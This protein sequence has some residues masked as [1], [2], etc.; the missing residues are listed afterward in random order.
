MTG[1]ARAVVAA[2]RRSARREEP[3]APRAQLPVAVDAILRSYAQV[4]FS[5]SRVVGLLLLGATLVVPEVGAVGL[6]GVLLATG[7]A[8]ALQF[9]RFAL[10]SGALGY[11]A[12]LVF[13]GIGAL[14]DRSPAFWALAVAAA[15][16]VVLLHVSLQGAMQRLLALPVL[17]VPFVLVFWVILA[18]VPHVRGLALVAHTPALS[19]GAFP[20]PEGIDTFLRALGAIFFQPH[21]TAGLLVLAALVV[22]SR[23]S[24]VHA[25]VGYAVAWVANAALLHLPGDSFVLYAGFNTVLTAVALGGVFYVPS[26]GSV[27]VAAAASLGS[28]LVSVGLMSVL[29]PVGLP[30][31]AAPL[32]LV[33]LVA[34]HAL[35]LRAVDARPRRVDFHSASPEEN[36]AWFHTRIARFRTGLP[37]R[38][39]LPF[40]GTWLCTQGNDGAHTHQGPWRHGVDFEV[41]D[42]TGQRFGGTGAS[43]SD[44]HCYRLPVVAPAAATV[45]RVVDGV[46]DN[47]IGD[48]HP[49][50]NW[51]N[52]VVLCVAPGLY[53]LLAHLSPGTVRVQEGQHV[54]AGTVLGLCGASGRAPVPHLHVQLQATPVVGDPTV[55]ISFHDVVVADGDAH[56]V[57]RSLVPV[58][59]Q[60]VRNLTVDPAR[61]EWTA[62]PPHA[63]RRFAVEGGP[64]LEVVADIDLLGN[65]SLRTDT[66]ARLFFENRGSSFFAYDVQGAS[67]PLLALYAALLKVPLDA[68]DDLRWTDVLWDRR[69]ETT[70]RAWTRDALEAFAPLPGRVMSYRFAV[71]GGRRVVLGQSADGRAP[72]LQTRAVLDGPRIAEVSLTVGSRTV[73]L[74]ELE[75]PCG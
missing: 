74:R 75:A 19:L 68:D 48:V 35:G 63:V 28:V 32:N 71:D 57:C 60:Q 37:V 3:P 4:L 47:D 39:Q 23:I 20:G 5:Q 73:T 1:L 49:T 18:G 58:E 44:Y 12:L 53:V 70:V 30:I 43:V 24:T 40:R 7:I 55:P 42:A 2:A 46:P 67:W 65:R 17:S 29:Q 64:E 51:G 27:L 62:M 54:A 8:W 6:L 16:L 61:A 45:V 15:L 10:R 50:D 22:H 38:L 72:R 21:W 59:D 66:G 11:N 9:D 56:E 34:L 31:L 25:L 33:V 26:G 14:L 41:A 36:L 52:L 69:F 13:L